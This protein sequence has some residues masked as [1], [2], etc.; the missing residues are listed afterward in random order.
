MSSSSSTGLIKTKKFGLHTKIY[1]FILPFFRLDTSASSDEIAA[2]VPWSQ[3]LGESI[4]ASI[5]T[6]FSGKYNSSSI[7]VAK[8]KVVYDNIT[9]R[10]DGKNIVPQIGEFH[11]TVPIVNAI[12]PQ[13]SEYSVVDHANAPVQEEVWRQRHDL[14]RKTQRQFQV[15]VNRCDQ[16]VQ[17][18]DQHSEFERKYRKVSNYTKVVPGNVHLVVPAIQNVEPL[19]NPTL[20]SSSSSSSST[21]SDMHP[22]VNAPTEAEYE[23]ALNTVVQYVIAK[24][25][26]AEPKSNVEV[27]AYNAGRYQILSH[28]SDGSALGLCLNNI[29][30]RVY[31]SLKK[32]FEQSQ[33]Y[34]CN[35]RARRVRKK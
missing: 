10:P 5:G 15:V 21:A 7:D 33:T 29:Y 11:G 1:D 22:A 6:T 20:A 34:L 24:S 12:L 14:K 35:A 8:V 13:I 4:V 2:V 9:L 30:R 17:A 31:E 27:N 25:H 19:V 26:G 23:S 3:E 16:F 32:E 18:G 28:S